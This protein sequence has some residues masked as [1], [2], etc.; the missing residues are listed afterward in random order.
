MTPNRMR[1]CWERN[2]PAFGSFVFSRDASTTEILG[3]AGYDF[4]VIDLEH[5]PIDL[6]DAA[7]HLRAATGAGIDALAR[8]PVVDPQQIGR[9]LD[10]GTD[11]I[12]LAHFGTDEPAAR[13]FAHLLRYAPQGE[14]PACSGV[15]ATAHGLRP[16]AEY[17]AAANANVLGI[18]LIEDVDV[19]PRLPE[20]L[21][22]API[23]AVMPGPGDLSVS[24]G[25]AGQPTH[26]RVRAAVDAILAAARAAGRRTGMYLN[27]PEEVSAWRSAGLD[28]FIYLFDTKL[29]GQA[30]AD[31]RSRIARA[32]GR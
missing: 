31:A 32:I 4:A 29:L 2:E 14:R 30:Y 19:I 21:H 28:F 12:M 13:R 3:A 20:L 26:A 9:L 7:G 24:M 17:V 5:S 16:Y 1:R 10:L 18:G 15:R 27:S 22:D 6:A 23:D 11:G 8:L 25:L